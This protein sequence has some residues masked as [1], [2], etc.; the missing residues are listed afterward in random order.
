M[1]RRRERTQITSICDEKGNITIDTTE[2]QN[3]IRNYFEALYSNKIEDSEG[4]NKFLK[5]YDLPRLSQEDI[6]NLNRPISSE[7]IE[8]AIKRLPTKKSPGPDGYTAKFYKTF[9]E[10][11]IP[12]LFNLFQEIEKEGTLPN[13]FY[14]ANVTLV[15]KP[16]K[17][18]SMK[19]N[20]R[21]IS[22]MNIDAKILNKILAN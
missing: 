13:S 19:E 1:K 5:S 17:D 2:I 7:E 12:I 6:Y 18:T 22:L 4:I 16:G 3:I 9:K 14:E 8:E 20:L 10:E 15:P 21:P 11:L